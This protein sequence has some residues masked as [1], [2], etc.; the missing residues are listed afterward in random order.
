LRV[1]TLSFL[2]AFT[3][4]A[5]AIGHL[6]SSSLE[7]VVVPSGQL[8]LK[9]F[10]WKPRVSSP[11]PAVLFCHGSGA[12]DAGHTA[13]LLITEAAERLA[14]VFLKHGYPFLYLFRR[15]Q[16]LSAGRTTFSSSSTSTSSIKASSSSADQKT[17]VIRV[18]RGQRTTELIVDRQLPMVGY[19]SSY[20]NTS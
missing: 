14:P 2:F 1:K 19:V 6:A 18:I 3:S 10:L 20:Q 5:L 4:V 16:G 17:G 8:R 12:G 9:A 13:D 15:G 7:I 11:G